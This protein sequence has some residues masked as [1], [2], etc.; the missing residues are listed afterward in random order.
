MRESLG[1]SVP[2]SDWQVECGFKPRQKAGVKKMEIRE[3]G[4]QDDHLET[5]REEVEVQ[6]DVSRDQELEVTE[7]R[8][9]LQRL[10]DKPRVDYNERSLARPREGED[11]AFVTIAKESEE[12]KE[13]LALAASKTQT[14]RITTR[15]LDIQTVSNSKEP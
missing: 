1:N 12:P 15:K 7:E 3:E 2:P 10:K 14:Q 11:V 4:A 9:R 8:R 5:Q 13:I 6:E